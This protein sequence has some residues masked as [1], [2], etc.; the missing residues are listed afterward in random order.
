MG[1]TKH[2]PSWWV[3]A[4]GRRGL[5]YLDKYLCQDIAS[6]SYITFNGWSALKVGNSRHQVTGQSCHLCQVQVVENSEKTCFKLPLFSTRP[7]DVGVAL[8]LRTRYL[9]VSDKRGAKHRGKDVNKRHLKTQ[10]SACGW[11]A[12]RWGVTVTGWWR[13]HQLVLLTRSRCCWGNQLNNILLASQ[14][15]QKRRSRLEVLQSCF[16]TV[17]HENSNLFITTACLLVFTPTY[18]VNV[19]AAQLYVFNQVSCS[20]MLPCVC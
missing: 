12:G 18:N 4:W 20:C 11:G 13:P 15:L 19:K 6:W 9:T 14:Q 3:P 2:K 10:R 7:A 8:L 1:E 16:L 17:W 5:Q